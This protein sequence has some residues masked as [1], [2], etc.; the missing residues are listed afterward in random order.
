MS[1]NKPPKTTIVTPPPRLAQLRRTRASLVDFGPAASR[2]LLG[3]SNPMLVGFGRFGTNFGQFLPN[4]CSIRATYGRFKSK[5]GRLWPISDSI[6]PSSGPTRPDSV[7]ISSVPG[8]VL[9]VWPN[10]AYPFFCAGGGGDRP[11]KTTSKRRGDAHPT[12]EGERSARTVRTLYCV[13]FHC[14]LHIRRC[15]SRLASASWAAASAGLCLVAGGAARGGA[16]RPRGPAT[17]GGRTCA[18]AR[19]SGASGGL[20][21]DL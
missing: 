12:E 5:S 15:A 20:G 3:N 16:A 17:S 7:Q 6:W 2:P 9:A 10:L 13:L 21:C 11:R 18:C 1:P 19:A 14:V 8:Q 4:I